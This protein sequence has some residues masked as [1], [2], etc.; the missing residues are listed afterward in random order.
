VQAV[1]ARQTGVASGM[2]TVMR[3][4]GG[5][6]GGQIEATFI[7]NSV[8]HGVPTVD[9]FIQATLVAAIALGVCTVASLAVPG[10]LLMLRQRGYRLES[11]APA[12]KEAA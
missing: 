7:A 3:S 6:I 5:A 11:P 1:P 12:A 10:R 2:N 8:V 9:G 4:L